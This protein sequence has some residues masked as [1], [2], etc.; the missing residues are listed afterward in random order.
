MKNERNVERAFLCALFLDKDILAEVITKVQPRMFADPNLGFIYSAVTSLWQRG[1]QP[2]MV[3]TETEMKKMDLARSQE[4]GGLSYFTAEMDNYR[5]EHNAQA[6]AAE[7]KRLYMLERLKKLFQKLGLTASQFETDYLELINTT[8]FELIAL[9][10][11]S[12]EE[13]PLVPL[14][15]LAAASIAKHRDRMNHK[16]DPYRMLTGI[17]QLDGITGGLYRGEQIVLGG[18]TSDGKTALA[19]FIA[20]NVA[21]AGKHVLHFSMEMTADQTASRFFAGYAGVEA[22]RLRIGGIRESDLGKMQQYTQKIQDLPYYFLNLSQPSIESIRAQA[23]LMHRKGRCDLIVIDYLHVLAQ[24]PRKGETT[25]SVVAHCVRGLK[26]IAVELN[27]AVL[28]ISQ[29][30]REVTKREG[31][32][33]VLS[34]LRD[35]GTIEQIADNVIILNR[36]ARFNILTDSHGRSTHD[37]MKLYVLK[38][39]NGSTGIAEVRH[40][41]SLTRFRNPEQTFQFEDEYAQ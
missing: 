34:D 40:N 31:Y 27:C 3:L 21:L 8:E 16:E 37:L 38:T 11:E 24:A 2:D 9:R 29:L 22:D 12:T 19:M 36:P 23:Q 41:S 15:E 10:E 25:E 14:A 26:A 17:N 35:S 7:I 13:Q 18:L 6:Y 33:P 30:N 39:R 28:V 5:L 4:M 32:I 1:E 20:M